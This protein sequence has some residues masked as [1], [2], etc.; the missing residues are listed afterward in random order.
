MDTT[1]KLLKSTI[2]SLRNEIN[3]TIA[4]FGCNKKIATIVQLS[5]FDKWSQLLN[6]LMQN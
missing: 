6:S 5:Y 2:Y 4:F 3:S 1:Y